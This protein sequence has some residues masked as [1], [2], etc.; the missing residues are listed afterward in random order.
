[1]KEA[2][3]KLGIGLLT[4][5][6]F[7]ILIFPVYFLAVP[8]S[9]KG[10]QSVPVSVADKRP[11]Q[12]I[13]KF[14]TQKET[15]TELFARVKASSDEL[16]CDKAIDMTGD[17]TKDPDLALFKTEAHQRGLSCEE[18]TPK[19]SRAKWEIEK[20]DENSVVASVEGE[21]IAGDKFRIMLKKDSCDEGFVFTSFYSAKKHPNIDE[22]EDKRIGARLMG[23]EGELLVLFSKPFLNGHVSFIS[24]NSGGILGIKDF[25]GK[26]DTIR[27]DLMDSE[28][29]KVSDYFD[30]QFNRWNTANM[31][32]TLDKAVEMCNA[33]TR[34]PSSEKP[35]ETV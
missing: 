35:V 2:I 15:E 6:A 34:E 4:W 26:R 10:K 12:T 33:L 19:N 27:L 17:W 3:R 13:S 30:I 28:T 5:V 22:L 24:M 31:S 29:L 32:A 21:T 18:W 25:F 14:Q 7:S 9:A 16:I 1:M 8:S 11:I 23:I 20:V